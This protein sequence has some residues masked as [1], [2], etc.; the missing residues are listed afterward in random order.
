MEKKDEEVNYS[1]NEGEEKSDDGMIT[2]SLD[3]EKEEQILKFRRERWRG[4]VQELRAETQN[5]RLSFLDLQ[6]KFSNSDNQACSIEVIDT[7]EAIYAYNKHKIDLLIKKIHQLLDQNPPLYDYWGDIIAHIENKWERIKRIYPDF[8]NPPKNVVEIIKKC[9]EYQCDIIYY[10]DSLTVPIRV[11]GHL[12]TLKAGYTLNFFDVFK[13]E[14]CSE[15]QSKKLLMSL[16]KHPTYLQ[17]IIDT[18]QGLIFK[19]EPPGKRWPS[20]ARIIG[21]I[22]F[23]GLIAI[24]GIAIFNGA[25]KTP[26]F[27]IITAMGGLVIPYILIVGGAIAHIVI[28]AI[29]EMSSSNDKAFKAVDDWLLWIHIKEVPILRGITILCIGFALLVVTFSI[30]TNDYITFF[31]AG[32]SI[33]SIGDLLIDK[34]DKMLTMKGE[35]LTKKVTMS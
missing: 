14:F 10:C 28:D 18:S 35:V 27:D 33:D 6:E 26:S 15:E 32:Y 4:L 34:F 13:D 20:Y 23:G 5:L 17:G 2:L 29:K 31:I 25:I 8:K 9:I 3:P 24:S 11:Q 7:H 21:A 22:I 19:V 1:H 12:K 30:S 16:A